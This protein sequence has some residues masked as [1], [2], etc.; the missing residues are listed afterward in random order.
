MQVL[1]NAKG[2]AAVVISILIFRNPYTYAGS[3]GYVITVV[4][5][6]LYYLAR[7]RAAHL[8]AAAAAH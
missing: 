8:Q 7:R 3:M 4:G 6:I 1:G 5:V 2:V